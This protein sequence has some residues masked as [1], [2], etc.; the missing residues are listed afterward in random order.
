MFWSLLQRGG[1]AG[2]KV[3][4][5][6]VCFLKQP[7]TRLAGLELGPMDL[8]RAWGANEG[9]ASLINYFLQLQRPLLSATD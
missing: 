9:P 8:P 1:R 4:V 7:Q 3:P 5:P 6:R 2:D